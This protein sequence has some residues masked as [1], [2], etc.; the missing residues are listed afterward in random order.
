[1]GFQRWTQTFCLIVFIG[2][3]L[4][5]AGD[6]VQSRSL[7]FFLRLDPSVTLVT[8]IASRN[9][10]LHL[11]PAV[12]L[13]VSTLILGRFF[14]GHICPMGTTLD[15]ADSLFAVSLKTQEPTV[16]LK[17][18]KYLILIVITASAIPGVSY[19]YLVSP[20]SL[21]TRFY[22]LI[23][24]PLV[25]LIARTLHHLLTPLWEALDINALLFL[26]I[27]PVRY[28]TQIFVLG[29]FIAL[30]CL[31]RLSPRFWCRYLCPA[32]AVFALFSRKPLIRRTV[33]DACTDCGNCSRSCV[34]G[35]IPDSDPTRTHFDECVV[36]LDCENTCP[37]KAISFQN[38]KE[39]SAAVKTSLPSRRRFLISGIS[40]LGFGLVGL[41]GLT[42]PLGS[43]TEGRV[44]S[45]T[46]IR[47]PAALPELEFLSRCL[48]CGECMVVCP[49]NTLQ[50]IWFEA[51][52]I[53][54]FS[55]VIVP[56]RGFCST[57]CHNC[58]NA[59][60]TH[61]IRIV[62]RIEREWAKT[63]TAVINRHKCL[64]WEQDQ[65]CMVCDEVCPFG[66]IEFSQ[67]PY[68]NVT[69][70]RVLE[71]RCTGCG[72]CEYHCP[73]QHQAAITVTPVNALR[74]KEGSFKSAGIKAGLKISREVA[75][76]T[77]Y[78]G[79]NNGI[80]NPGFDPETAPGFDPD[81][82]HDVEFPEANTD[83]QG[84]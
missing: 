26:Q 51:G 78:P 43:K 15:F 56:R 42:S 54:L 55:P 37:E 25:N 57:G 76:K 10:L 23:V 62:P 52:M 12:I 32:G 35:A 33:S 79:N 69:T 71:D 6:L 60:P 53:G 2:L 5:G 61:A 9:F 45:Q 68:L 36:C 1:M 83:K 28:T 63:G 27:S 39:K 48:R 21:I 72:Y 24:L 50:P 29:Y 80:F 40:G 47:P 13:I 8:A 82:A 22:G 16:F 19:L 46:L 20:L 66:A 41:T 11:F 4:L 64:A 7:D 81:L 59:C 65:K 75:H 34:M 70:P 14:C 58:A 84:D 49:T 38:N 31:S 73:V 44:T 67:E 77:S 30:F 3:L 18:V 17:P 74:I